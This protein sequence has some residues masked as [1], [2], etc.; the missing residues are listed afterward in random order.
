MIQFQDKMEANMQEQKLTIEAMKAWL[1]EVI[2]KL[3]RQSEIQAELIMKQEE[4][5]RKMQK[6]HEQSLRKQ[7]ELVKE[8]AKMAKTRSKMA[9][10]QD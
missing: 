5:E 10:K 1:M 2:L 9:K 4:M 8:E 6:H 7:V 3:K